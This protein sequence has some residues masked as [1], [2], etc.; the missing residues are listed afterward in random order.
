MRSDTKAVD[1]WELKGHRGGM[2]CRGVGG[3]LTG[4]SVDLLIIDDPVKNAKEAASKSVQNDVWDWYQT[5]AKTRFTAT[6]VQI[7]IMTRWHEEDLAGKLMQKEA[8]GWEILE[9]PALA[10]EDDPLGRKE[11]EPL[12]PEIGKDKDF[13]DEIRH[14]PKGEDGKRSGGTSAHWFSAMYQQRP[15]PD[16]GNMWK[17]QWWQYYDRL[18]VEEANPIGYT[19]IDLAH[20][21]TTRADWTILATWIRIGKDLYLRDIQKGKWEF[22][23]VLQK[24]IDARDEWGMPILAEETTNTLPLIQGLAGIDVGHRALPT[25]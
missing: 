4:R 24:C 14:G 5:T 21:K 22:P 6:A 9:L 12:W 3:G 17:R 15:S 7:L 25:E 16:E 23:T 2:I 13:F 19:I 1:E 11:G 20:T 18:P 10:R 8:G